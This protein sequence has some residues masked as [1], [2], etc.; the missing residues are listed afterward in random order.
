[1]ICNIDIGTQSM[2]AT[3]TR[4]RLDYTYTYGVYRSRGYS[5]CPPELQRGYLHLHRPVDCRALFEE[6]T[7]VAT[8]KAL[9][10]VLSISGA[11]S[12]CLLIHSRVGQPCSGGDCG[13]GCGR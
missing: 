2:I 1:M 4:C 3:L 5:V 12:S 13:E 10:A 11:A 8:L 6:V 9:G 7:L